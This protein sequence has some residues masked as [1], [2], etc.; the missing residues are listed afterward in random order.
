M[1][2]DLLQR[3]TGASAAAVRQMTWRW[4]RA[5][6]AETGRLGSGPSWVWATR[7]GIDT[8]GRHPYSVNQPS[9]ARLAHIRAVARV[10]MAIEKK[11][12]HQNPGWRSERE[13]RWEL[14]Q[15]RSGE[16][17]RVHMP[18]AE[19][20]FD[21]PDGVRRRQALEV[22]LTPKAVVRT[23]A[24][25][26]Q[27]LHEGIGLGPEYRSVLYVASKEARPVVERAKQELGPA[28][29]RVIVWDLR[30]EEV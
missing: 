21:A 28:A 4:R 27:L 15:R 26:R 6:W 24:I 20:E 8:F 25:M 14:G 11:N 23:L 19:V 12:E 10:R 13:L 18:D 2:V 16:A 3:L 1:P 17:A 30:E 29:E 5:G 9:A 22:E 7:E